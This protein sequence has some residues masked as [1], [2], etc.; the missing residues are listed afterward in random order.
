VDFQQA[1]ETQRHRL[2]RIVT[3]LV[4]MA[5]VWSV[6]PVADGVFVW[7]R[8][9][10]DSVL[11]RAE[12]AAQNLVIAEAGLMATRLGSDV[13]RRRFFAAPLSDVTQPETIVSL[14]DLQARLKALQALLHD[15]PRHGLR[16]LRRAEKRARRTLRPSPATQNA[17]SSAVSIFTIGAER[18]PMNRVERPPDKRGR[19]LQMRP[20]LPP[21]FGRE[22]M[23][24]GA[25]G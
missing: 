4:V 17:P 14:P 15:L 22:A 2:L 8:E 11:S 7:L 20:S 24:V 19:Y 13:D 16:L 1:I 9:F 21:V 18:L 12:L 3:G 6:A 25:T 23:A 5:R 10:I